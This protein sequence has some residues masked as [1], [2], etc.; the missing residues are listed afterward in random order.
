M[1]CIL[2]HVSNILHVYINTKV[3]LPLT[4]S[5][6]INHSGDEE[7]QEIRGGDSGN[8]DPLEMVGLLPSA[9]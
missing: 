7:Y 2:K 1:D 5:Q 8:G 6:R 9:L 4:G 3:L